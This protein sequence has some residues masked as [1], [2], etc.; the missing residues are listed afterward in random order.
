MHLVLITTVLLRV[1]R[2]AE[3]MIPMMTVMTRLIVTKNSQCRAMT[4]TSAK[5]NSNR[6]CRQRVAIEDSVTYGL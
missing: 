3:M 4:P 6:A 1:K 2:S 5:S